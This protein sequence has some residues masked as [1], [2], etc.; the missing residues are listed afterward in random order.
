M[1]NITQ[2]FVTVLHGKLAFGDI[3]RSSDGLYIVILQS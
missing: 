2:R 3:I 1:T